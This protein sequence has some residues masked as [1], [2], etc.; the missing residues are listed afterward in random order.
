MTCRLYM[1]ALKSYRNPS[2]C[3]GSGWNAVSFVVRARSSALSFPT[4]SAWLSR[5]PK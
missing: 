4:V 1:E 3:L 2:D 5:C